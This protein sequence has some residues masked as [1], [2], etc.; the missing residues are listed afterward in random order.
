[1]YLLH[2][3]HASYKAYFFSYWIREAIAV[4]L[5]LAVVYEIFKNLFTP[6]PALRRLATL[7]FQWGIGTL[8]F[9]GLAVVWAQS[10]A[11]QNSLATAVLVAEEATRIV[12]IGLLMFLFICSTAFGLH[13]RQ[14]VFGIAVGLGI[15]VAVELVAI[16]MRGYWGS[17]AQHALAVV[18]AITF[19]LSLMMWI[20][21]L[22]VPEEET[23][24]TDVPHG[25]QLEQWNKVLTEFI[26]Q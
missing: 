15:F 21:Y 3:V 17:G 11:A 8:L 20:G 5:G 6:Y 22:L 24:R 7:I 12:E 13:W 19:N 25:G 1:M 23:I 10:S 26:Y 9:L 18:R 14:Y 16:T 2:Q 4:L